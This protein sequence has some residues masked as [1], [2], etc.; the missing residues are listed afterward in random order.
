MSAPAILFS[1]MEPP[2]GWTE[3]FHH[4]Y[5]TDHIPAR[6]ALPGF[7]RAERFE[8]LDGTPAYLAVYELTGLGALA[9]AG[10]ETLKRDPSDETKT[11]LANVRGFTR[12]TCVETSDTGPS[13]RG[14]GDV[15]SVVAFAVPPADEA[16]FEDW[17]LDEHVGLLMRAPDWLRVR[18]Y[19][20]V[21]G[22]PAP[23]T[24][25][26]L[27]ELAS[28]DVMDSPE[29]TAARNGPKRAALADRPWF[30]TSGRWLYRSIFRA[31]AASAT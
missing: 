30:A 19:R 8:A 9:T 25:L 3:R 11:M 1:Q 15:L 28:A 31:E 12:Y 27:H 10:Y 17:Y 4:W 21:S 23:W 2:E 20:V 7:E 18:R 26:A 24:H 16:Q 22:E 6:L 13:P 29:R 5:E 14:R